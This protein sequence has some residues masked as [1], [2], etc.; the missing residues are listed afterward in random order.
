MKRLGIF[1]TLVSFL[2]GLA[3]SSA[4]HF[5]GNPSLAP[6]GPQPPIPSQATSSVPNPRN[7]NPPP[8]DKP[9]GSEL[10]SDSPLPGSEEWLGKRCRDLCES[11]PE[12]AF[13]A[14]MACWGFDGKALEAAAAA[15]V[16]RD[17]DAAKR[18]LADCPD[19][20]SKSVLLSALMEAEVTR[21]PAGMLAWAEENLEGYVKRKALPAGMEAL[22]KL[23]PAK[24]LEVLAD[25]PGGA[26]RL[27]SIIKAIPEILRQD[28]VAASEWINQNV[29]PAEQDLIKLFSCMRYLKANPEAGLA[30]IST[31]PADFHPFLAQGIAIAAKSEAT[32]TFAQVTS[33]IQSLPLENQDTAI[34]IVAGDLSF[35]QD[36][37]GR[38]I[39]EFLASLRT[40]SARAAAIETFTVSQLNAASNGIPL[41]EIPWF[42]Q[43]QTPEDKQSAARVVPYQTNLTEAQRTDILNRLK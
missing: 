6:A 34:R 38:S 43:L 9:M 36:Q 27:N 41:S 35:K 29:A 11:D 17:P 5:M 40:P 4:I 7:P 42:S 8:S 31:I 22:A 18:L 32:N 20:R 21:D 30:S 37:S 25:W 15:L 12:S 33:V 24:A 16:K 39:G 23:D 13:R 19:L 2:T 26:L 10:V 28:P 3:A 14:G 1:F